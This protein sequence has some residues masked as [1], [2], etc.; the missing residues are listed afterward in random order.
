MKLVYFRRVRKI[1]KKKTQIPLE[2]FSWNLVL[3]YFFRKY[4][5]EFKFH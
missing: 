5:K 4:V 2:G 1:A 3:E